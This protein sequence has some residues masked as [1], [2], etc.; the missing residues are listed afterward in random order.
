MFSIFRT[1]TARIITVAKTPAVIMMGSEIKKKPY[2]AQFSEYAL[3]S[4]AQPTKNAD[5]SEHSHNIMDRAGRIFLLVLKTPMIIRVTDIV[6][7]RII[8]GISMQFIFLSVSKHRDH[9]PEEQQGRRTWLKDHDIL[10]YFGDEAATPFRSGEL[11]LLDA[12]R[13]TFDY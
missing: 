7:K 9:R 12:L 13:F 1:F 3:S 4:Q 6:T 2:I 10:T 5:T 8:M 11:A